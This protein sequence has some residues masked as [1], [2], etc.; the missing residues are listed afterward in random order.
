MSSS[1]WL[2]ELMQVAAGGNKHKVTLQ[3]Y[4]HRR[5]NFGHIYAIE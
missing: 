2:S 4:R 1:L 5:R 3:E